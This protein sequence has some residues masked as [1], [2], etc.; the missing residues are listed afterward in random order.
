MT[1]R[2]HIQPVSPEAHLFQ[3]TLS[4]DTPDPAGQVFWLPTWIPG[5]YLIREFARHIVAITAS[6]GKREL[7]INKLD[8]MRWR[9]EPVEGS[10]S[11]RYLVYANDLSVRGA[12]LDQTRGF[13]NGTSVFLAVHGQE[14]APCEVVIAKPAD[15]VLHDW[16]VATSLTRSDAKPWGFGGYRAANYDELIDHPVEMGEF[17]RIGF[18]ACGVP[19]ELVIAGRHHADMKRLKRDIKKICEAQIRF[20]GEPAP[21]DRYV[22]LTL[23]IGDGY[24]GLEHRASTALICS[25]DD[26]PLEHEPEMKP[27]YRQ[28]LS[29][30][31]HEYFHTWNVKRIKPA[32]FAPYTLDQEGYTR[33]LWAF[34]GI[35][36]YYDDLFLRRTGLI[37]PQEYLDLLAQAMTSVQRNPGR[38][39][40]TLEEASLDAWVKYYRQ[41]ENS[42]NSLVSYYVKGSLLA[43]ALDLS[44]RQKSGGAK[45]LDDIMH[46]LW[47]RFGKQFDA[48]GQGVGEQEWEQIA[49][50]VAGVDLGD[51]FE[52]GLRSTK[53]L[54]LAELLAQ[55]GV[56]TQLRVA[57][58][59]GDK[60]GWVDNPP[61][62]GLTLGIRTG[63]ENG[64]L[65]V[66]H[67]LSQSA[68]EK[69]GL[70]AGDVLLALD[71]LRVTPGNFETQLSRCSAGK[72]RH[73]HFFRRDELMRCEITPRQQEA[74]TW[75]MRSGDAEAA[76]ANLRQSWLG[77]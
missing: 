67:V 75:G 26:L 68:A 13:F 71:D 57:A 1:I 43:L 44:I 17:S 40:Q 39:L 22:F 65:K 20:F 9:L 32:A 51:F 6:S 5:S 54:P 29:L 23:A 37:T 14:D 4:L 19:H 76:I 31:S 36:S 33:L 42:P 34:E 15:K 56:E 46:A 62:P 45:S 10:V 72:K 7:V 28:F 70:A 18:K 69:A 30:V 48:H 66:T 27:G 3:V 2:Y 24:G 35:T 53:E 41:D 12:F 50:E 60:G 8:K 21:F 47:Q 64:Y 11:L 16:E 25:R 59:S 38:T 55:F 73:L 61:K 74:D 58:G 49:Q 63:A 52:Q 77:D